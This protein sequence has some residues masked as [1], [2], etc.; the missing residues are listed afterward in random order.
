[1]GHILPIPQKRLI[2][3]H[4][5]SSPTCRNCWLLLS[6]RL[7]TENCPLKGAVLA[8]SHSVPKGSLCPVTNQGRVTMA[9]F[10]HAGQLWQAISASELL[11]GA[12]E[13]C[14]LTLMPCNFPSAESC[15]STFHRCSWDDSKDFSSPTS[16]SKDFSSPTSN[17]VLNHFYCLPPV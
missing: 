6:H 5:Y 2:G 12:S 8:R 11:M 13:I 3:H 16:K 7:G 15:F 14:L 17:S 10:L 9:L 1:M 4:F